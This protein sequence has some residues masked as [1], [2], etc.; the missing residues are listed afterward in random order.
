MVRMTETKTETYLTIEDVARVIGV[1][2]DSMRVYHQRAARNRRA[3]KPRPG[4]LPPP[5]E[6]FGRSPVW[7]ESTISAWIDARPG[8]GAGGGRPPREG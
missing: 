2:V 7:T 5:D 4:D 3:S 6:T 8:R 1:G